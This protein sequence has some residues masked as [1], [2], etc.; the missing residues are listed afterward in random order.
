MHLMLARIRDDAMAFSAERQHRITL[1]SETEQPLVGIAGELRSAFSNLIF[2]AV[3]YTPDG[4]AIQIRW[5]H[6]DADAHLQVMD[7]GPG[8]APEHISQ[9]TERFYRIDSSRN[10]HTGGS[11][12]GLAIVKH[13]LLRHQGRL[14]ITSELGKGSCFTCHF[15]ASRLV[16][17]GQALGE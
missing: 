16:R 13:V 15:P 1:H 5:W 10:S 7:N 11:G 3:K 4:S 8:I 2:N 9:L 6:D 12:L 14:E 17:T